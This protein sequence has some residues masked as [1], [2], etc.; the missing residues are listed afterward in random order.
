MIKFKI[1]LN[2]NLCWHTALLEFQMRQLN[3]DI[4]RFI[5]DYF[6]LSLPIFL[7]TVCVVSIC[8]LMWKIC[9]SSILDFILTFWF[10]VCIFFL[11]A[12]TFVYL[13]LC[14]SNNWSV[15][16][17]WQPNAKKSNRS[18][19]EKLLFTVEIE[20]KKKTTRFFLLC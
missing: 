4:L 12:L 7:L 18:R 14:L 1:L 5:F 15:N 10:G 16:R 8:N 19:N 13:S 20:K 9:K 3:C 2:M 6:S 11:F 17:Y